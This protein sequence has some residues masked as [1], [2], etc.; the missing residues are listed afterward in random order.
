MEPGEVPAAAVSDD[1]NVLL[2]RQPTL[3]EQ[4]S[5]LTL[6]QMEERLESVFGRV[7][8]HPPHEEQVVMG[9]KKRRKDE[10]LDDLC[11]A[12][13]EAACC[14]CPPGP[15]RRTYRRLSGV[16]VCP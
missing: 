2:E 10:L 4:L 3:R 13:E 15:R 6:E 12:Y 11:A 5:P 7:P 16:M 8:R 1:D 9:Y 14:S